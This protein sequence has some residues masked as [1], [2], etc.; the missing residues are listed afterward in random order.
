MVTPLTELGDLDSKGLKK[1]ISHILAGGAHGL[2]LLG[3]TGE[4]PSLGHKLRKQ[5]IT[6]TCAIINKRVPVLVCIT[7]TS[8]SESLEIATHAAAAGAD[9]LVVAAPYYFPISQEEMQE[10]L[11]TL[12]P[13]L[14]LPFILYNMPSCTKLHLSLQ[15]VKKAKELGAIGIKDSS[16]DL[17]YLY[18]LLKEFRNDD[19]FSVFTGSESFIP[20]IIEAGGD[21]AV[22]GGANFFP[23]LFVEFY[24]ASLANDVERIRVLRKKVSWINDKLYHIVTQESRYVRSTKCVLSVMGICADHTAAPL[25]PLDATQRAEIKARI[26][27]FS[28]SNEYRTSP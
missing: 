14:P 25:R 4:G 17:P 28:Y 13:S 7:D 10:Y 27:E 18:A 11:H 1:L 16:G 19:G 9:I 24:E 15:T 22:A 12:V 26:E 2:F 21:G 5:L 8:I 23:R 6:E 20:E 3:T